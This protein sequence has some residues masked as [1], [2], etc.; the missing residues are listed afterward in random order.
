MKPFFSLQESTANV[1][2]WKRQLQSY[3]EENQRLKIRYQDLEISKEAVATSSSDSSLALGN[4][5]TDELRKEIILQRSK[6]E[7]LE[8]DIMK[9]EIELKAANKSLK[10]IQNDPMVQ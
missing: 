10:E 7:S 8:S 6:I 4:A 2:E 3:K 5:E 9:Q 1:D